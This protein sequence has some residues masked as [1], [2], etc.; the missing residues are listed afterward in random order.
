M[1]ELVRIG[2]SLERDLLERFDSLLSERGVENRSEAL[3]DLIRDSLVEANLDE[4]TEAIGSVTIIYDHRKRE[5]ASGLTSVQHAH[6]HHVISS[7][8][9]HVDDAHCL[10]V[11]VLRGKHGE[12]S[13]LADRLL[14]TKG[15]LHG[16]LVVTSVEAITG[17]AEASLEHHHEH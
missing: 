2:V 8:H 14:R 13:R 1:A 7:M 3:R 4:E 11:I 15:V 9:V 16:K 10:E 12:I 6:G 17:A 5:L